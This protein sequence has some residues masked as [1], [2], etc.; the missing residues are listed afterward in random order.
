MAA[1]TAGARPPP[2]CPQPP[3]PPSPTP[4]GYGS[5][6]Q[7]ASYVSVFSM[8]QR[9]LGTAGGLLAAGTYLFHSYALLVACER[10]GG[11]VVGG[12]P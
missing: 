2:P 11:G 4:T 10:G 12:R 7:G 9:T 3:P 1:P 8:A 6:R 5:P